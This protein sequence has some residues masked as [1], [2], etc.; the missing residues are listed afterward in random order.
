[1]ISNNVNNIKKGFKVSRQIINDFHDEYNFLS[2]FYPSVVVVDDISFPTVEHAFQ[3]LK[4]KNRTEENLR[5][6][7]KLS[8]PNDA[9]KLGRRIELRSD[10]D[11]VKYQIMY[12]LVYQKFSKHKQLR[13][14]L[15][16][17]DNA[18]LIEGNTWGDV[19]WG[20]C[21]GKGENWLGRILMQ[22][23][24]TLIYKA[25]INKRSKDLKLNTK[26]TVKNLD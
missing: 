19:I 24:D 23:R 3:A 1:M 17:T 20:T 10:W 2:N 25:R 9:K 21:G 15:I 4:L 14:K 22:V 16:K 5:H 8:D 26:I 11:E 6:F 13:S 18:I 7:S 12:D